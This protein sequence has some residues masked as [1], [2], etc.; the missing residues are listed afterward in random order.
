MESIQPQCWQKNA[1]AACGN[2][3]SS[4][5]RGDQGQRNVVGIMVNGPTHTVKPAIRRLEAGRHGS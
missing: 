5:E 4:S 3:K 2:L 1:G